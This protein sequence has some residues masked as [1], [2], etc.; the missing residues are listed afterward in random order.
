MGVA[1]PTTAMIFAFGPVGSM[2]GLILPPVMWSRVY[3]KKHTVNQVIAGA[4][5]GFLLTTIQLFI[6]YKLT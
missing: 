2:L 4:T 1:G 5:L 6:R 3:L